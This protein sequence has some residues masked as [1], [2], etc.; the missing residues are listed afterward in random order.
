MRVPKAVI[1]AASPAQRTLPLQ[2]LVDSDGEEK[3][4]LRI[5]AAHVRAAGID[6]IG[7]VIHPGDEQPFQ[8]AAGPEARNLTFIPQHDARGYGHAVWCARDFVGGSAF[9]HVVGDHVYVFQSGGARALVDLAANEDC[10]VSAV[11][12]TRET[13]LPQYG[14]AAGPRVTGRPNLYRI[15]TVIEKPTPTEAE[16]KLIVTGLRAGY[17]LAFFGMHVLTPSVFEILGGVLEG[18]RKAALSDALAELA[19]REQYLAMLS[20]GQRY[21]LGLRYGFLTAQL[22]LSL[23]GPEASSV[24]SRVLEVV[25]ARPAEAAQ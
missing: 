17:Y 16:R 1:T 9:L 23:N 22:A 5:I 14:V 19:R 15:E 11:Q 3:S 18:G 24:L 25:A 7:V 2:T 10:S 8:I 20:G 4:V 13:L 6:E 21:D 12:P